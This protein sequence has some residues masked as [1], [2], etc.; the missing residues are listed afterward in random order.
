MEL[1]TL[2]DATLRRIGSASGFGSVSHN[3]VRRITEVPDSRPETLRELILTMAEE[4]GES[5]ENLRTIQQGNALNHNLLPGAIV[6]DIQ[7]RNIQYNYPYAVC[8][9]YPALKIGER[10]FKLD[11]VKKQL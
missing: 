7:G 9:A 4:K 8:Y 5:R 10:Y 3:E 11:E 1:V 2:A 6:F